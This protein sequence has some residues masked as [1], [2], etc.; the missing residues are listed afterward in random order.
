MSGSGRPPWS[1]DAVWAA[2][3]GRDI[4]P[5]A[6]D[7]RTHVT[8]GMLV[9]DDG[10]RLDE[11]LVSGENSEWFVKADDHL[12]VHLKTPAVRNPRLTAAPPASHVEVHAAMIMRERGLTHATLVINND[13]ICRGVFGCPQAVAVVLPEGSSLTV[14]TRGAQVPSELEGRQRA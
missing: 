2:E 3:V 1:G 7:P 5:E 12:R 10:H 8:T 13:R 14:W 4:D 11:L 6:T 9:D